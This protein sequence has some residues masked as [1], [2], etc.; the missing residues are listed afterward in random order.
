[1]TE[2]YRNQNVWRLFMQNPEIQ[3]GLQVAGFVSLPFVT[4]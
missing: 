4:G 3:L 1:M 2:N